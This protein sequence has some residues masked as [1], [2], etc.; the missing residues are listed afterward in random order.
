MLQPFAI[1]MRMKDVFFD[2]AAI[3]NRMTKANRK[4]LSKAGAFIRRRARSSLRRRKKRSEPGQP[5]SVHTSDRVATLK[6]ILF[7]YEPQAE[8]LVV[9]PV[10]LNRQAVLG[11]QLDSATVPQVHEFGAMGGY[12]FVGAARRIMPLPIRNHFGIA[13]GSTSLSPRGR[14][15][16]LN[17]HYRKLTF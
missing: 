14:L 4:P 12:L 8:T 17:R 9:G 13:Y 11:P 15:M 5:P 3:K 16:T 10:R 2:R 7:A 1:T 6:N